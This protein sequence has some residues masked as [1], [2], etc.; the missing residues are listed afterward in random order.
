MVARRVARD[1]TQA[2]LA[3]RGSWE[4]ETAGAAA[5]SERAFP[6]SVKPI[7][8]AIGPVI[9]AGRSFSITF[10]PSFLTIIPAAIETSP[11]MTMPNCTMAI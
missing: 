2:K 5:A 6:A 1:I 8:M 4:S 7:T 3:A 11:D 9:V 10:L